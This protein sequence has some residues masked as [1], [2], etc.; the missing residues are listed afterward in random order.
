MMAIESSSRG[1]RVSFRARI[2]DAA[3]RRL[4]PD[5]KRRIRRAEGAVVARMGKLWWTKVGRGRSAFHSGDYEKAQQLLTEAIMRRPKSSEALRW[6][7]R[8]AMRRGAISDAATLAMRQAEGSR[9]PAD[10]LSARHVAGRLRETDAHWQPIVSAPAPLPARGRRVLY[11]AKE[12]RPFL[13]NGFCTR[14][15]ESLQSL[16]RAGRD[17]IAV[18]MPGFPGILG[19]ADSPTQTQV[20]DVVYHHLLPG[21]GQL[22]KLLAFDEYVEL[23]TQ[24]LAGFVGRH[25]PALLHVGSGHRGFETALAGSAAAHWAGVP[26]IYE[27]R[28]FFETTWTA[29]ARYREQGEYYHRRFATE[30]RMMRSAD[31]VIT[32]S[33]PMRDEIADE[34]GVAAEKI[35]VV[36]NAVDLERFTPRDRDP[37]LRQRLG[38]TGMYTIGYVSNLSHPREGQ[39]V[40][41]KAVSTLRRQGH[42]VSGLLVG[43][44]K[45]RDELERLARRLG[46]GQQVVFT[47]DVPFD[48]VADYYA[49]IDLFVVPRINERAAR[50]V[51][52]MK[53]FEAMAMNIPVLVADLPALVE[54][55]GAGERAH[56]FRAEDP[57]S[58]AQAVVTLMN[59]PDR[60]A[61]LVGNAG[62]WVRQERDWSA[63]ARAFGTAYDELL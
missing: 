34:H 5:T 59:A 60:V 3:R 10:W 35:R 45:R 42:R 9:A 12:S 52:P 20:E 43:D 37:T 57:Q 54:I 25:Q 48:Q 23:A 13:H 55:A 50:M 63:V 41:I 32:L 11:L 19:V 4:S 39:D 49:Q 1:D 24:V 21:S 6:S 53:P 51:S 38:L 44:G 56:V 27:V 8:A 58:L 40:L 31:L 36:P 61:R 2:E 17:I 26:W 30:T 14:S 22:V 28:S 47:G 62:R 15:H 33:S 46:V 7:S 18:T 16:L 29:D